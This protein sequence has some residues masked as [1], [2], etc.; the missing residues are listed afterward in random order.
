MFLLGTVLQQGVSRPSGCDKAG[1]RTGCIKK[2]HGPAQ[3]SPATLLPFGRAAPKRIG[4]G[5]Q[6][7]S[8]GPEQRP[9]SHLPKW[10]LTG[11]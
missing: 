11:S 10:D 7:A 6:V 4:A 2:Q 9:K 3:G 8:G 1:G 5:S